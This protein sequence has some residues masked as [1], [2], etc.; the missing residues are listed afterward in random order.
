MKRTL[1]VIY[2]IIIIV[3]VQAQDTIRYGEDSR[4][5]YYDWDSTSCMDS[6]NP[7]SLS[8]YSGTPLQDLLE[9]N[10]IIFAPGTDI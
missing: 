7:W 9:G 6:T 2:L 3:S 4:Y 8:S 5:Y 10:C 1:L